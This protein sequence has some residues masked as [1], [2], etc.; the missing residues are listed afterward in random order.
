ME[1]E[2]QLYSMPR[3]RLRIT[4][5]VKHLEFSFVTLSKRFRFLRKTAQRGREAKKTVLA[6][7]KKNI[8][9]VKGTQAMGSRR[10]SSTET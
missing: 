9:P 10:K 2:R 5:I 7:K 4:L 8:T 6:L 1:R 3:M